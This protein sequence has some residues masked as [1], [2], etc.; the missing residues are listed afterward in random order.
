MVAG[1]APAFRFLN[2]FGQKIANLAARPVVSARG[3]AQGGRRLGAITD[4]GFQAIATSIRFASAS[5]FFM[6]KLSVAALIA[7]VCVLSSSAY[8]G[9]SVSTGVSPSSGIFKPL[10]QPCP[11]G[12]TET[13]VYDK[14][15]KPVGRI[16]V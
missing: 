14:Q 1:R 6:S 2:Q 10:P 7:A 12:K 5:R 8:A 13:V 16:C 11:I 15:G 3:F 4:R 9:P